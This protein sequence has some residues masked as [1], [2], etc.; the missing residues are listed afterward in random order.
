M[1]NQQPA[2]LSKPGVGALDD[3]AA[4]VSSEF[5]AV[6]VASE[7]AVLSVR[8]DPL[9]A[10]FLQPLAQRV[11]VV[12][13]VGDHPFRLLPGTPPSTSTIHFVPLPRLVFPTAEPPFSPER[14]CRP[15]KSPPTSTAP[16]RPAPPA[17]PATRRATRPAPPTVSA[18]ASRW[19]ATD[20]C[21]AETATPRRSAISIKCLPNTPGWTPT[22]GPACPCAASA[23][24]A[25]ARSIPT[26][27]RSTTR[28]ASCP[29]KKLTKPPP[30]PGSTK[31]E[32]EP[33]YETRSSLLERSREVA[34]W[35]RRP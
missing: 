22:D 25:K 8:D 34:S 32:A 28:I 14:N 4:L 3:P 33:I 9:D 27:R 1:T 5:A 20:I 31:L 10:A 12:G 21:R 19:P 26:A 6:L 18:A 16:R 15:E 29:C 35:K 11:G 13:A 7:F 2:K 17:A 23:P 24:A 30:S